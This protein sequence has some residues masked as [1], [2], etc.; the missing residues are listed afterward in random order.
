MV[1]HWHMSNDEKNAQVVK[2]PGVS[3]SYLCYNK[4]LHLHIPQYTS[5]YTY[6]PLKHRHH[7]VRAVDGASAEI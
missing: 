5:S 6:V 3:S 4:N 2:V 1:F 7:A